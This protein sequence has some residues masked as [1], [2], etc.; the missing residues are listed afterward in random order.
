MKRVLILAYYF[1]PLGMGGV[2]RAAKWAKFLPRFGWEPLILTVRPIRYHAFDPSLLEEVVKRPIF[3][4][5]SFDPAR[6]AARI[7]PARKETAPAAAT[8]SGI[9]PKLLRLLFLPD[10]KIGWFPFATKTARRLI[11]ELRPRAVVTT[12]PP[13]TAHLV[14][15][16]LKK[17][18]GLPWL[19]DF[20]DYWLGGEYVPTPSPVHRY[21]HERWAQKVAFR[22]D[23]VLAVSV[24]IL[25]SLKSLDPRA[26]EKFEYLPNGF[27]PEDLKDLVPRKFEKKTLLYS[28]SLGGVNDPQF[29]FEGLK[30]LT[31]ADPDLL[32][33]WQIVVLGQPVQSVE[34]PA[35]IKKWIRFE[36]YTSHRESLGALLGATGLLFFLSPGVNP[37]MMTGKIF[38]YVASGRPIFAVLPDFSAAAE[39]LRTYAFGKMVTDFRTKTIARELKAF[40]QENWDTKRKAQRDHFLEIFSRENQTKRLSQ[41]L[42]RI[43]TP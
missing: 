28:G 12:S 41:I 7:F 20:R 40:L 13:L 14:G 2:Q 9:L 22:A 17:Q 35:Q 5:E 10:S 37:G 25:A 15:L 19:A 43:S 26:R 16:K 3:R 11:E 21:L 4:T 29:F 8:T 27:D 18:F 31:Q 38:E 1:P 6:L 32:R 42:E 30:R 39:V 34:V 36:P 23:A 24:P 33:N